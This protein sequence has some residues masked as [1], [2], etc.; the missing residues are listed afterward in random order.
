MIQVR[1]LRH[2]LLTGAALALLVLRADGAPIRV[3][4][5]NIRYGTAPDGEHAWTNRRDVLIETIRAANPDLLGTQETLEF[6]RHELALAL[7]DHD[8]FGAGRDDGGERGEMCAVFVRRS[9]FERLAGGHFWLSETPDVPGS[10]SWDSALPRMVTWVKLR[11]RSA[12]N[13]PALLFCNTHF[14]HR[15]PRARLESARRLREFI[16]REGRG[17]RVV[18]T[19]DF[20]AGEDDPPYAVLFGA[21]DSGPSPLQDAYRM[22]H[23]VRQADEGTFHGFRADAVGGPRI[24]WIGVSRGARVL[25]ATIL[26]TARAGRL[27]SDHFP[28]FAVI[29]FETGS[30]AAAGLSRSGDAQ[31]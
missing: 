12:Q 13:T 17:L 28:V 21:A 2:V 9:R 27:P 1:C 20:N 5:F 10:R 26:R 14:D 24:D 16:E 15:G 29:E 11:D 19:G 31:P 30:D 22:A 7:P 3:M 18:V 23:P 25:E 8:A 6:Q 4:S